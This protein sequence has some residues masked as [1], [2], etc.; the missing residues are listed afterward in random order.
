VT[1]RRQQR[2]QMAVSGF[3]FPAAQR[4]RERAKLALTVH[5]AVMLDQLL[6][7]YIGAEWIQRKRRTSARAIRRKLKALVWA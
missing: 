4:W 1:K 5:E 3:S 7:Q 6:A 2:R